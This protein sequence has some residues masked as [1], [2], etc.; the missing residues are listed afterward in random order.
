MNHLHRI[1]PAP[2]IDIAAL[3]FLFVTHG[4]CQDALADRGSRHFSLSECVQIN[5]CTCGLLFEFAHAHVSIV[6]VAGFKK[7][8]TNKTASN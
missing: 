7:K 5:I 8:Y 6:T 2:W 1:T 4:D 3:I